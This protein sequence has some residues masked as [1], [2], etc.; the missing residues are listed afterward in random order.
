MARKNRMSLKTWGNKGVTHMNKK[1]KHEYDEYDE[2]GR[3]LVPHIFQ[4]GFVKPSGFNQA[5]LARACKLDEA[6]INKQLKGK[7]RSR[8]KDVI[9][10]IILNGGFNSHDEIIP[11]V[12]Q[13]L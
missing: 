11:K 5:A 4:A 8:L 3:Q 2:F 10:V 6:I 12:S 7:Y 9:P 1:R 13:N